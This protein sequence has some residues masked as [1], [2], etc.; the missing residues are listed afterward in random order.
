MK[1]PKHVFD[2]AQ[3]RRNRVEAISL[4]QQGWGYT[5]IAKTLGIAHAT[6]WR[7][8]NATDEEFE[9][10]IDSRCRERDGRWRCTVCREYRDRADYYGQS[11]GK[12]RN[13]CRY[14][15]EKQRRVLG[16]AP[17]P[18]SL[19]HPPGM[20]RCRRCLVAKPLDAFADHPR[21]IFGKQSKC[22]YCVYEAYH[23]DP[24]RIR[25]DGR[26]VRDAKRDKRLQRLYGITLADFEDLLALQKRQCAICFHDLGTGHRRDVHVDHCHRTGRVRGLLCGPCNTSLGGFVDDPARL[27]NA[28]KYLQREERV[29]A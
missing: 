12:P 8:V 15:E 21:G 3:Q 16:M 17:G 6:A 25:A 27:A 22:R 14:C 7:Y 5:K 1:V 2:P 23:A 29:S 19:D 4:R 26:T 28:I 10:L 20:K 9:A 11:A 13:T 18:Q 24:D